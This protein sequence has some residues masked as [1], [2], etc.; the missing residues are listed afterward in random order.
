MDLKSSFT[1]PPVAT[2]QSPGKDWAK[3]GQHT[4]AYIRKLK[5]RHKNEHNHREPDEEKKQSG[6]RDNNA[7]HHDK[8]KEGTEHIDITV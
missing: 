3:P 8:T 1:S 7:S 2:V 6:S 4:P 5:T